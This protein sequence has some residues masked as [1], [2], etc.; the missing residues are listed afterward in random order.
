MDFVDVE[1]Y[2]EMSDR[3]EKCW[4]KIVVVRNV[5]L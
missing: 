5:S 3:E 2:N 4:N 1:R